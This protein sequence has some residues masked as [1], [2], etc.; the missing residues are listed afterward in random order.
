VTK[1]KL[2]KAEGKVLFEA[3]LDASDGWVH[4]G[5]GRL[6]FGQGRMQL[7]GIGGGQGGLACHAFCPLDIPDG[8]RLDYT[9]SAEFNQGLLITFIGLKGLN[10]E[11]FLSGLPA[12]QGIFAE[13]NGEHPDRFAPTSRSYH[14]SISRYN[15]EGEHTGVSNWRKNPGMK[16]MAQAGDPCR[17]VGQDYDISIVK[18]GRD[19]QLGVNGELVSAFRDDDPDRAT[20]PADGKIGFRAVGSKVVFNISRFRVTALG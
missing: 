15:D 6:V 9:F 20:V 8:F 3:A 14:V 5:I 19:A 17:R 4:E 12:R 1:G 13:Y 10:G 7:D 2:A 11:D 18:N 16:M